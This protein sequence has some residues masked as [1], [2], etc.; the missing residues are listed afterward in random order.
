[1]LKF[2]AANNVTP[3]S[4]PPQVPGVWLEG[5]HRM[6]GWLTFHHAN[7]L[8]SCN[9]PFVIHSDPPTASLLFDPDIRLFHGRPATCAIRVLSESQRN[10][11]LRCS[12]T[13]QIVRAE[14][15]A[16]VSSLDKDLRQM[17]LD[18]Y[19]P[20]AANEVRNWIEESLGDRLPPGDLLDAL[21]DG[22]ALCRQVHVYRIRSRPRPNRCA[23]L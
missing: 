22:V 2:W 14:N 18:K 5:I 13:R 9:Q 11:R 4:R 3:V 10:Q 1:M 17:R 21:K 16:T 8:C 20:K 6:Q 7:L 12:T 15:M 19:T 23:D